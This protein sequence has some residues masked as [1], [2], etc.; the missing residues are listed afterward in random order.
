MKDIITSLDQI[1]NDEVR[2][3]IFRKNDRK[4]RAFCDSQTSYLQVPNA[5]F[6]GQ[7]ADVGPHDILSYAFLDA[8]NTNAEFGLAL[9]RVTA[10]GHDPTSPLNLTTGVP[11]YITGAVK[12]ATQTGDLV[13]G[14]GVHQMIAPGTKASDAFTG[15][16]G[17]EQGQTV[18]VL[19]KG[20]IWVFCEDIVDPTK[21]VYARYSANV[22][23]KIGAFS[24]AS[25][26]G[27]NDLLDG[28]KFLTAT[29]ANGQLAVLELNLPA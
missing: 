19:R 8:V 9:V 3:S 22:F 17:I 11:S 13:L 28:A 21:S 7:L 14:V 16:Q 29:T 12:L 24:G 1:P 4:S 2:E 27:H 5:A 20:R 15:Q 6:Q 23:T 25:D 26:G 18:N 10:A